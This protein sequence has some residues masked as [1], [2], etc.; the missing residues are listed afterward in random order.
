M[1]NVFHKFIEQLTESVDA[2][3]LRDALAE[4]ASS[5]DVPLFAYIFPWPRPRRAT[6]LISTYP[7]PWTSH[8][9]HNR[10]EEVDPVIQ[11]ARHYKETFHWGTDGSDVKLSAAGQKL[12]DEA[13]QFGIRHGFTIP[14]HVHKDLLLRPYT[15]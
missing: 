11:Q 7:P 1:D 5:L 9:L 3:D 2:T 12:M 8:Y 4:T 13:V 14:I 15:G 10:Y 6:D